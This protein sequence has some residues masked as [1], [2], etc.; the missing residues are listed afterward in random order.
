MA[1]MGEDDKELSWAEKARRD[2]APAGEIGQSDGA[3]GGTKEPSRSQ[4]EAAEL[5]RWASQSSSR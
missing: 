4:K 3:G 2:K 5:I 1:E